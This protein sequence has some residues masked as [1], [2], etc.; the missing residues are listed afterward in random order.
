VDS[1]CYLV[2]PSRLLVFLEG[3]SSSFSVKFLY[4]NHVFGN[5]VLDTAGRF[6]GLFTSSLRQGRKEGSFELGIPQRKR[7]LESECV[8]LS[9]VLVQGLILSLSFGHQARRSRLVYVSVPERG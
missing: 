3:G 1:L 6:H 8:V 9:L 5:G 2:K 7:V 4:V